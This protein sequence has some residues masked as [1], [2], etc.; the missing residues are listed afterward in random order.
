[1]T[2]AID[3]RGLDAIHEGRLDAA[4]RPLAGTATGTILVLATIE[5]VAELL[6]ELNRHLADGRDVLVVAPML[7]SHVGLWTDEDR[8]RPRAEKIARDTVAEI[9][10]TGIPVRGRVGDADPLAALDDVMRTESVVDLIVMGPASDCANWFEHDLVADAR[11][12]YDIPVTVLSGSVGAPCPWRAASR[13]SGRVTILLVLGV[14]VALGLALTGA[15]Q[16]WLVGELALVLGIVV[17]DIVAHL[18]IVGGLAWLA[19]GPL[20]SRGSARTKTKIPPSS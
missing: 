20:A 10:A 7:A 8:W 5:P 15:G 13:W 1:M 4:G 14:V 19:V 6:G 17:V 3:E 9:A 12:R 11:R 16:T 18:A 2:V